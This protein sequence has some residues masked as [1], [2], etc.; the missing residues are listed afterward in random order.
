M[1]MSPREQVAQNIADT[2]VFGGLNDSYGVMK[3]KETSNGKTYWSVTFC[4]A[5]ILDGVIR[6]YSPKFIMV[7]WMTAIRTLPHRGQ[8]VFHSEEA[9]KTFLIKSFIG[10]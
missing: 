9:V 10:S 6:V 1:N 8:E 7:K 5:R 2:C 4:K 3:E